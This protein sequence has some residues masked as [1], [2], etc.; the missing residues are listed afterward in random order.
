[1]PGRALGRFTLAFAH[2][3]QNRDVASALVVFLPFWLVPWFVH[4]SR[5]L[6]RRTKAGAFLVGSAPLPLL[7]S[8]TGNRI[9]QGLLLTA[10]VLTT[11][12]FALW[13]PAFRETR[14]GR[15]WFAESG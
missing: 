5:R 8:N 1:M 6:D 14:I 7:F 10:M 15:W 4:A 3:W 11:L 9:E 13:G 2:P 12:G